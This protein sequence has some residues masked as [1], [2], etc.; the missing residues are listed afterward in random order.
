MRR[1][2]ITC[3]T[4]L[5]AVGSLAPASADVVI[6]SGA[7][8][9]LHGGSMLMAGTDVIVSGQFSMG[10]GSL[11]DMGSFS[12]PASGNAALDTGLIVLTGDWSNTGNIHPGSSRVQFVDGATGT[13]Q[14]LGSSNFHDLSFVSSNGKHYAFEVGSTQTVAGSLTIQGT[15]ANPIQFQ[16]TSAPQVANINL[17]AGGSQSI[18]HV[19]VS[20]VH[21]TGQHLAPSLQNEGGSGNDQGWFG[22]G[23]GGGGSITSTPVPTTSQWAALTLGLLLMLF[24]LQRLAKTRTSKATTP[25]HHS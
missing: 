2:A 3:L 9:D 5:A 18:A 13:S 21:A 10:S 12:V 17:A 11:L 22:Q 25:Q 23:T 19:G 4:L 14:I 16:S 8:L 1:C 6:P 20:N 24:G 15:A 7:S